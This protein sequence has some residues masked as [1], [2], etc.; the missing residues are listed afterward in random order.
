[1]MSVN[2]IKQL[3]SER[4]PDDILNLLNIGSEE[5]VELLDDYIVDHQEEIDRVI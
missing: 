3:L 4:D 1:M 5:L 2:E